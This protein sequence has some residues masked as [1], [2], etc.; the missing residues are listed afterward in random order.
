V[1]PNR[2]RHRPWW[3][4]KGAMQWCGRHR[5]AGMASSWCPECQPE[6]KT[7]KEKYVGVLC[8]DDP[9]DPNCPP[10]V[11]MNERGTINKVIIG[12]KVVSEE[13]VDE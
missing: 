10:T 3:V 11:P 7:T 5:W 8:P 12:H 1:T 13:E 4:P 2:R 6:G 9:Y